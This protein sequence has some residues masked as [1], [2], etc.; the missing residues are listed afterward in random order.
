MLRRRGFQF[1]M[2]FNSFG[3]FRH[4][5]GGNLFFGGHGIRS[6]QGRH[7]GNGYASLWFRPRQQWMLAPARPFVIEF[8]C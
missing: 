8:G 6:L 5:S 3:P 4:T 2:T 1:L 7:E